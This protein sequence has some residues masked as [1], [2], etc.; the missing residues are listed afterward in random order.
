MTIR[1][2]LLLLIFGT[3]TYSCSQDAVSNHDEEVIFGDSP[4]LLSVEQVA[5]LLDSKLPPLVLEISKSEK[6]HQGHLA[7]AI[8]LWRPDYEDGDNYP[9]GGMKASRERMAE[10]LGKLG[11]KQDE[12]I[13]IYCTRGGVDAA[14]L[15]WIL[16]GFGHEQVVIMNGGKTAWIQ[17]GYPLTKE[18]PARRPPTDYQ[19]PQPEILNHSVSLEEVLA[20]ISDTNTIIVDTREDYEFYGIPH[21]ANGSVVRFKEGAFACGAIPG[22]RHLNWSESVDLHSHHTFKS[23]ADLHHN[24]QREG[25]HPDKKVIVYCQ[26]GVRSAHTTFVLRE[27]LGYPDVKNYDGSWIEWSYHFKADTSGKRALHTSP[28]E[29]ETIYLAM[30]DSLER[31]SIN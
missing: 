3:V 10:L 13:I 6:Y 11:A 27:L 9:F 5:A 29:T 12:P 14:R 2:L 26:S 15:Q 16:Q 20:A 18:Q 25:I 7:E 17:A 22:A 24:F 4:Y 8:N 23:L 19:F 1:Y 21:I 31:I 28:E 30:V